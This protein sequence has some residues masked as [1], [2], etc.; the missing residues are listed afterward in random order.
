MFHI[1][2]QCLISREGEA[3]GAQFFVIVG[4]AV[5]GDGEGAVDGFAGD[6]LFAADGAGEEEGVEVVGDGFG[7]GE[8]EGDGRLACGRVG[9]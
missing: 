9:S 6:V 1:D 7:V 2:R 3:G 5:A 8:V 4:R